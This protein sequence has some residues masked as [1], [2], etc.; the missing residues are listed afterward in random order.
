MARK[1][2]CHATG[3]YGTSD[4]F[5]K[6]GKYY[7]KN[8]EVFEKQEYLK[9]KRKELIDYICNEFFGYGDGEPFPTFIPRCLNEL[10]YYDDTVIL[11]TFKSYNNIIHQAL[12]S[13]DFKNTYNAFAYMMAVVKNH[14]ADVSRELDS[15][16]FH[17]KKN[18]SREFEE[19]PQ[20]NQMTKSA[21][22]L[23]AFLDADDF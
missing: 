22:N 15:L 9:N 5:V 2:K 13:I 11:E 4:S 7:Y 23:S 12:R 14:I 10:S 19:I 3:E 8:Q 17:E 16:K 18:N 6:I 20:N 21:N 1:V